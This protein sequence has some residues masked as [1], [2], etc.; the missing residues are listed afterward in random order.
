MRRFPLFVAAP[1]AIALAVSACGKP[2]PDANASLDAMDSALINGAVTDGNSLG[3][4]IKVDPR[5]LAAAG[6]PAGTGVT[7][8]AHAGVARMGEA[9]VTEAADGGVQLSS[10]CLADLPYANG[11]AAKLPADLPMMAGATLQEAAGKDTPCVLRIA[12][13]SAPGDRATVAD[14]YAAKAKTAGYSVARSEM[15]DDLILTG[16]KFGGA[17]DIMIGATTAGRTDVDYIWTRD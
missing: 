7:Q 1:L 10:E 9:P 14:W 3:G 11:W 17:Y 6:H 2:R 12:S 8:S 4:A 16:A 15:G 13:F 5:K